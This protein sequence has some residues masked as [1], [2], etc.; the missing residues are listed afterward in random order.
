MEGSEEVE[1][2]KTEGIKNGGE[3]KRQQEPNLILVKD[4]E[5]KTNS[6]REK[7]EEK[8]TDTEVMEECMDD[9]KH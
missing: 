1:R 8:W 6:K 5:S 4:R 7:R 3:I 9:R 2:S